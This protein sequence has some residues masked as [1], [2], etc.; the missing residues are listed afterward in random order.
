MVY[1]LEVAVGSML[2]LLNKLPQAE[3]AKH[4]NKHMY[5]HACQIINK[6][7]NRVVCDLKIH[8]L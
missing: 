7:F 5:I 3:F 1:P 4:H 2:I 6:S 8:Y